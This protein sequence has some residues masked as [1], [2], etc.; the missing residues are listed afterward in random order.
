MI[1]EEE[2]RFMNYWEQNRLRKRKWIWKLA[3]GLPLAV[4]LS[5][6]IFVNFLSGWYT[7]ASMEINVDKSGILVVLVGLVGIVIFV[8][9]FSARHK[10]ELNEQRFLELKA[11]IKE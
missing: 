1:T 7:R 5:A 9:I 4:L 11:K 8:V 6:A 2:K 10:W 3:A